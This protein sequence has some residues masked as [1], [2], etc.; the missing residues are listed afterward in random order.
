MKSMIKSWAIILSIVLALSLLHR[1]KPQ[2][3]DADVKAK[4]ESAL[5]SNPNVTIGVK[6]GKVTLSGIVAT[7]EEKRNL[8]ATAKD[9]DPQNIK[10]VI[11]DLTVA[12]LPQDSVT[13]DAELKT[14]L[15][16]IIKGHPSL[17]GQVK[18][19][20][21]QLS[22]SLEQQNVQQLRIRLEELHLK[23]LDMSSV[24]VK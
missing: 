19:G 16:E 22:G 5:G 12:E 15:Q 2:V 3:S 6:R 13:N 14:Q 10:D 21:I 20:V 18:D 23:E 7:E 17:T 1:C 24:A 4:V 9:A 8:T 11:D